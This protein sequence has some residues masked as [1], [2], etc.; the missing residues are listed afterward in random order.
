MFTGLI[1]EVGR[2]VSTVRSRNIFEVV[3]EAGMVLDDLKIGDSIA[4]SGVCQTVTDL[5]NSTFTVQAVEETLARTTFGKLKKGDPVN[6][7]RALR[8]NDRLGGHIVQ[9]HVDGVGRVVTVQEHA[10]N[11]LMSIASET[12]LEKYIAE[13]GSIAIEGI[14]LT[15]TFTRRGEFGV[16]II[17]HTFKT[18]TLTSIRRGDEVNLETDIIAK[19]IEKLIIGKSVNKSDLR[20]DTLQDLGF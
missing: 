15:V 18:T 9:G 17:P 8:L 12:S 19:Y 7:E 16:S 1:E 5:V 3:V 13:K 2:I 11:V 14:S 6:L 4:I 20:L 10:E